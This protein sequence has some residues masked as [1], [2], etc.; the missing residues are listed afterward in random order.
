MN[1]ENAKEGSKIMC[2]VIFGIFILAAVYS[3]FIYL[4]SFEYNL[5]SRPLIDELKIMN[6]YLR[7]M[8]ENKQE[9]VPI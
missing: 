5:Y 8:A 7:K 3:M 9:L 2:G 4:Q 1:T 6:G